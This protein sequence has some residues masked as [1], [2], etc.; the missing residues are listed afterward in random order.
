MSMEKLKRFTLVFFFLVCFFLYGMGIIKIECPFFKF[1]GFYCPGCGITRC[2]RS[3]LKL[4]FYQAFRFNPYV[5]LLLPLLI[6]YVFYLGYIWIFQ[7]EDK[8]SNRIP[9]WLLNSVVITLLFYGIVRNIA[10]FDWLKPT[11]IR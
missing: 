4:D 9:K 5:C 7:K 11:Y 2:L 1:T 10:P 3:L 8:I 6:P